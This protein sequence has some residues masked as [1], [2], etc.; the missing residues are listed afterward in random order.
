MNVVC[1]SFCADEY[2][3]SRS[4]H[5]YP[6]LKEAASEYRPGWSS[7]QGGDR[8]FVSR[9]QAGP[10][11]HLHHYGLESRFGPQKPQNKRKSILW[12]NPD[13]HFSVPKHRGSNR[14]RLGTIELVL[15]PSH[16][17]GRRLEFNPGGVFH[18]HPLGALSHLFHALGH[19][20]PRIK[21]NIPI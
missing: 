1:L 21:V 15:T 16:R 8:G 17:A 3:G 2:L 20:Q 7:H 12:P 18:F 6:R 13:V 4:P 9:T 19:L 11:S 10:P 14:G 5:T